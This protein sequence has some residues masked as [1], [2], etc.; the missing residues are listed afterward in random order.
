[1][2]L[3]DRDPMISVRNHQLLL[4]LSYTGDVTELADFALHVWY[5]AVGSASPLI[6]VELGADSAVVCSL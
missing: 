5:S 3:N 6:L 2:V 4:L 1:M